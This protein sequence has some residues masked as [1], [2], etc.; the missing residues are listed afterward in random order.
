M[1]AVHFKEFTQ[2]STAIA[3]TKAI[4]AQHS[5]RLTNRNAWADAFSKG[6]NIVG[7]GYNWTSMTLQLTG[8]KWN[9]LFFG[10]VQTVE[11]F[12]FHDVAVHLVE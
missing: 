1:V 11:A 5:E 10:W 2:V 3:A 6:A 8:N 12:N 7:R 4:G 9:F